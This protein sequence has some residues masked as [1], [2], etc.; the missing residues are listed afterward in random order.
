MSARN[1]RSPSAARFSEPGAF[2]ASTAGRNAD[3]EPSALDYSTV[4]GEGTGERGR[5]GGEEG[6]GGGGGEDRARELERLAGER[7]QRH[8]H[9]EDHGREREPVAFALLPQP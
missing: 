9:Q 7:P 1:M 3:R 2:R 6:G 4:A 8:R 5:I